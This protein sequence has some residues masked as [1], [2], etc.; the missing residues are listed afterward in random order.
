MANSLATCKVTLGYSGPG[1]TQSVTKTVSAPF[2]AL[3]EGVIDVPDG[4]LGAVAFDVPFG[5]VGT[6]ATGLLIINNS[7]QD[8]SLK[9][10]GSAALQHVPSGGMLLIAN[11]VEASSVPLT[12]ASL[13]T[14]AAQT[15]AGSVTFVVLGDP[16]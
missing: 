14:T 1:G 5:S 2:Q 3:S 13:T 9:L 4:T 11:P 7:G 16:T 8:L 10:N 12:A 15:G 6:E